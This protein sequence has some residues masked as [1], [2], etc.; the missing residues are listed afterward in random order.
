MD[1]IIRGVAKSRTR[2][3]DFHFHVTDSLESL[4]RRGPG[5]FGDKRHRGA[6]RRTGRRL[7]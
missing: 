7:G 2:L 3:S 6:G 1:C 4:F 5:W